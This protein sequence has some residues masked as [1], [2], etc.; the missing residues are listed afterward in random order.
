MQESRGNM[1]RSIIALRTIDSRVGK[2]LMQTGL[3]LASSVGQFVRAH[4]LCGIELVAV[5]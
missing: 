5:S 2:M 1:G 4:G 3:I